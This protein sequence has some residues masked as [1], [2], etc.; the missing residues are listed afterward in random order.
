MMPE[1][2]HVREGNEWRLRLGGL[3]AEIWLADDNST[4][5]STIFWTDGTIIL[6]NDYDCLK[7]AKAGCLEIMNR[8]QQ[9]H[10]DDTA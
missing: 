5:R 10:I 7:K 3:A 2:W 6:A 1:R 8:L 4:Y 9:E